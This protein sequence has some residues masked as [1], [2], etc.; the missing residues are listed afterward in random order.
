L[1]KVEPCIG[2]VP[3]HSKY[4]KVYAMIC[5][6]FNVENSKYIG[7]MEASP[8]HNEDFCDA[9]G[10]CLGC[11]GEDECMYSRDGSHM[12]VKYVSSI[13]EVKKIA[14]QYNSTASWY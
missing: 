4:T 3:F 14:S 5:F 7:Y 12:W 13:E 1:R 11:Y 6:F 10:D 8:K 9:C 2:A